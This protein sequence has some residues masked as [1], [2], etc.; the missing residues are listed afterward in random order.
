LAAIG[1][2][3]GQLNEIWRTRGTA[4]TPCEKLTPGHWTEKTTIV[5]VQWEQALGAALTGIEGPESSPELAAWLRSIGEPLELYRSIARENRA[6][7][8]VYTAPRTVRLL[9][10]RLGEAET[11]SLL[12]R[13]WGLAT[14]AYTAVEEARSFLNFLNSLHLTIPGLDADVAGDLNMLDQNDTVLQ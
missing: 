3:L 11:R 8:L 1:K 5:P 13:F 10:T 6:S 4:S 7:A 14:P 9:L 12:A 2:M